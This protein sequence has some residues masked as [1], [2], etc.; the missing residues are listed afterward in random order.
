[1]GLKITKS[2]SDKL[3]I[4]AR[5]KRRIRAKVI[6]SAERPRL[7]V[8]KTNKLVVA[9]LIDDTKGVTLLRVQTPK[10]KTANIKLSTELGK[11]LASQAKTKG[12][13]AVVFD[14]AGRLYHGRVAAVAAGARE[15]GLSF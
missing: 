14:R 10:N 3:S 8:T 2:T 12:I 11:D 9:Q 7:C 13:S 5:R 15:A 1:M 4:R 6:G